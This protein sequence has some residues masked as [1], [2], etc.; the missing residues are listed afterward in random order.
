M[1]KAE[2]E[3]E[4]ERKKILL[5]GPGKVIKRLKSSPCGGADMVS[6]S[7]GDIL[8]EQ[9]GKKNIHHHVTPPSST[10]R[11]ALNQRALYQLTMKMTGLPCSN[12]ILKSIAMPERS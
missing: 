12:K 8:C 3:R 6:I 4:R 10:P 2:K 5:I 9:E 1:I 7:T 11:S